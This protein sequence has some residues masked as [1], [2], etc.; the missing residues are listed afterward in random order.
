MKKKY[1]CTKIDLEIKKSNKPHIYHTFN[2]SCFIHISFAVVPLLRNKFSKFDTVFINKVVK[3]NCHPSRKLSSSSSNS[4]SSNK[5]LALQ[6]GINKHFLNNFYRV[7]G[8]VLHTET[9]EQMSL[10]TALCNVICLIMLS[11]QNLKIHHD[12]L[13]TAE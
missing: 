11:C 13:K 1:S 7:L 8:T 5:P 3:L 6:P 10:Y 2:H 9:N 12:K 4:N